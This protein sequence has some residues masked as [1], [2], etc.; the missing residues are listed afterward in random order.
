MRTKRLTKRSL[1]LFIFIDKGDYIK[2]QNQD[3]ELN[4]G[5]DPNLTAVVLSASSSWV[6]KR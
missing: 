1:K 6:E 3:M 4:T 2:Y 5:C